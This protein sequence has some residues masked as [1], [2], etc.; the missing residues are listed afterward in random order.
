MADF[1]LPAVF[2]L[3]AVFEFMTVH[4]RVIMVIY[5]SQC[6]SNYGICSR[7]GIHE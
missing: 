7:K 3:K 6:R 2:E 1:E 5:Y 4:L